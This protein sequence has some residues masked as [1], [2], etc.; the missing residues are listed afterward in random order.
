MLG[1]PGNIGGAVA[2]NAGSHGQSLGPRVE[3]V[4]TVDF[5][6][7][8]RVR[9]TQEI[10]FSY[11]HCGLKDAVITEAVF[12]LPKVPRE[13]VQ[14]RLEEYR[15]YRAAT[16]DLHHPSAGC[17]FK[18][19]DIPGFS[20]GRL[21][22]EAGLKGLRVGQAQVSEK[23]ANFIVNLGGATAADVRCLIEKVQKAVREKSQVA[24]ETEVKILK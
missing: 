15:Q 7:E 2:M 6:G 5:D 21:I 18:N 1:I 19:P 23:H 14:A 10:P 16:Q 20:S 12:S 3:S 22:D 11:R 24:L 9:R 13:E 17:M 8:R 4:T